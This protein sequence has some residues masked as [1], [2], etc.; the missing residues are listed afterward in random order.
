VCDCRHRICHCHGH[1]KPH[2]IHFRGRQLQH[3]A[4]GIRVGDPVRHHDQHQQQQSLRDGDSVANQIWHRQRVS[5]RHHITHAHGH[6]LAIGVRVHNGYP[7][8]QRHSIGIGYPHGHSN[9]QRHP[10]SY[11]YGLTVFVRQCDR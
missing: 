11:E 8:F 1:A 10:H 9:G 7:H 4:V 5:H 6:E 3:H 2:V